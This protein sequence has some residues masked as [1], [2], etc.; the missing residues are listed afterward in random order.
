MTPFD[1]VAWLCSW[2]APLGL[3]IALAATAVLL[4]GGRS[5]EPSFQGALPIVAVAAGI[6]GLVTHG[7]L[8]VHVMTATFLTKEERSSLLRAL[9]LSAGYGQWRAIMRGELPSGR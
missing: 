6:V 3:G 8:T 2:C 5:S 7:L 4:L 9:Y 1:R